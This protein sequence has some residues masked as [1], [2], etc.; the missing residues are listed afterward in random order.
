MVLSPTGLGSE[1]EWMNEWIGWR[2]P[3]AIAYDRP[4]LSSERTLHKDYDRRCSI[5]KK[6]SGRE[7]QEAQSQDEL[8]G[9]KSSVV[10]WLWLW[11]E[12][13]ESYSCEKT[14]VSSWRRGKL[15][16]QEERERPPLEAATK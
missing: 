7:S 14:E 11:V 13:I 2:G 9:G 8:I 16:N 3:A 10:K 12:S 5:G 4:I 1:N 6:Y 15:A